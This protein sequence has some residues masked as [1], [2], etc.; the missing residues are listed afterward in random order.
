MHTLVAENSLL[1]ELWAYW[2]AKRRNGGAPRPSDI[3]L[4]E[5][6]RLVPQLE[7]IERDAIGTLR[8]RPART[9]MSRGFLAPPGR[10]LHET[11]PTS[12]LAAANRQLEMAWKTGRPLCARN[13]DAAGG[14]VERVLTRVALPLVEAGRVMALLTVQIH[15]CRVGTHAHWPRRRLES[16]LEQI[17]F[18][19]TPAPAQELPQAA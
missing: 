16:D 2:C 5:I 15:D 13:R 4:A 12:R 7:I 10:F 6:P 1:A 19:D 17:G 14:T 11:I 18:L 3:D 8:C 9:G